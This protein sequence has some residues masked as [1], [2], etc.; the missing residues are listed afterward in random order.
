MTNFFN[1]KKLLNYGL[2][3][4]AVSLS[5]LFVACND[6]N[7]WNTQNGYGRI[8][9]KVASDATVTD[10]VPLRAGSD[11]TAPE[12]NQFKLSLSKDDGSQSYSWESVDLFPTDKDFPIGTYTLE[13]SYGSLDDE[14]FERPYFY[15]ATVF[16]VEEEEV[17]T[18]LVTAKLANTMVSID[19]TDDFKHFF[20]TYSTQL[21]SEGGDFITFI[22]GEDRAAFL[23]PGQITVTMSITKQNGLSATIEP[24]KITAL[25]QHHYHLTFDANEGDN[26]DA[27]LVINFDDSLENEDVVIDLSDDLMLSP[28]PKVTAKGFTPDVPL[29]LIE[30]SAPEATTAFVI[31]AMGGIASATLTTESDYLISLGFPAE[32]DLVAATAA[33]QALFS[34]YGLEVM[35]LW[36]NPDKMAQVDLTNLLS[37]IRGSGTHKFSLVVK[38]KLTKVNLPVTLQVTT[39][40]VEL[41]ILDAPGIDLDANEATLQVAYNGPSP[42]KNITVEALDDYGVWKQCE[43]KSVAA[44]SRSTENYNITFTIPNNGDD[45]QVRVKYKGVVKDTATIKRVGVSLSLQSSADVW[46]THA[47]LKLTKKSSQDVSGIKFFASVGGGSWQSIDGTVSADASTV[48]FT[49]LTAGTAYKISASDTGAYEEGY[50]VASFT[51]EAAAQP[52]NANMDSWCHDDG[53]KKTVISLSGSVGGTIYQYFPKASTSDSD[54]WATRNAMTTDKTTNNPTMYYT[55]YSGTYGVT[56]VS[57]QAAEICTEGWSQNAANTFTNSSTGICYNKSAGM[58]FMGSYSYDASSKKETITYG[59]P[60][61]SRPTSLTFQYLFSPV[62]SES[63]RAYVVVENRDGSNVT[64]LGRG[65]LVS[66]TEVTSWKSTTIDITY[67]NTQLKATHAYIVFLS[68]NASSPTVKPVKGDASAA[69]NYWDSRYIGNKLTVDNIQFNY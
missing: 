53:W 56:G 34:T 32:I 41:S 29:E 63:F 59:R 2:L 40:P 69:K 20:P 27:Q 51:T 58:L 54:Y 21:H 6:E 36:R 52:Q 46:A 25:A 38:D 4:S 57:G 23:K 15:G 47:T 13:A 18:P 35:G 8:A 5:G 64:E 68:S 14:G 55:Y 17:S 50:P 48:T 22:P 31:T 10:V 1:M 11:L 26:G 61:T 19:Y 67:T 16:N 12:P 39:E 62:N 37:N 49:G 33:Q 42:S 9:P 60:F 28:E 7:P 43:V 45:E 30:G 24:A 66:D 44:A 3:L 65:E